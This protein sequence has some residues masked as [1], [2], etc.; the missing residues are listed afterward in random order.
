MNIELSP[1]AAAHWEGARTGELRVLHCNSCQ[2]EWYPPAKHCPNCL[3][4]DI[5][6][7]SVA[8]SGRVTGWCQFHRVYFPDLNLPIPYTVLSIELDNGVQLYANPERPD[9][10]FDVGSRVSAVFVPHG[11][12]QALVRF[13]LSDVTE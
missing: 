7:K 5:L 6:W 1:N 9:D 10:I 4:D 13:K 12:D 3:S 8:R 11:P 2:H